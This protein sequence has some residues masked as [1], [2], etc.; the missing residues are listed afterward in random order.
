MSRRPHA[1]VS[2]TASAAVSAPYG[3]SPFHLDVVVI[4]E[5]WEDVPGLEALVQR[6]AAAVSAEPRARIPRGAEAV[7]ALDSDG[8][9]KDLNRQFR[10]VDKPTNVLSFPAGPAHSGLAPTHLGDIVLARQTVMAEAADL[11]IP[12]ADH[13]AHLVTHGLLHLVGFDHQSEPDAD[14]MESLER[15]ILAT[16]GIADPYADRSD[17]RD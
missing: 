8:G 14:V 11:G 9:V 1:D 17:D 5:T 12:V 2:A 10:D 6:V 7:L 3:P 15:V 4:D 13:I 16:L